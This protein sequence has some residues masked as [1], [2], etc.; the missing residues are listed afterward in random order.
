MEGRIRRS[1]G[2]TPAFDVRCWLALSVRRCLLCSQIE[3]D[4]LLI[5]PV[6]DLTDN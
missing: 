4:S 3:E 2:Q 5:S 6:R 1:E